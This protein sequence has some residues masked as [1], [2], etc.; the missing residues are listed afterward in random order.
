MRRWL[1]QKLVQSRGFTIAELL[2]VIAVI[3]ILAT[4]V[5]VGYGAVVNNTRDTALKA[6][7]EK[8]ADIIKLE[9]LDND[10][11]PVGGAT[12]ALTGDSTV[13]NG[14]NVT[15]DADSYDI[16]VNNLFYCAGSLADNDEFALVAQSVTGK[17]FAYVSNEGMTELD[18]IP[19]PWDY[20]GIC[21]SVGFEAPYT[22]SYGYNPSPEYGWFA[23]AQAEGAIAGGCPE[24]YIVVPGNAAFGTDDFC[25][26][27]YEAKNVG[28]V[29]TSQASDT[30]W[31]SISQT[32]AISTAAAACSGCH[33]ITDPEW[34]TIAA[35]V[36]SVGSN[37]SGGTVGSGELYRGH[38]DNSPSATIEAG[39]DDGDGFVNTGNVSGNQR[40]T[41]TLTNGEVIWDFSGN[42]QEWVNATIAGGAQPGLVGDAS[43]TT[44]QYND[45]SLLWNGLPS[46]AQPANV[47]S[48]AGSW[49]ST[50][51]IGRLI[52]NYND[53]T[54][55][56][57]SRSGGYS[58]NSVA[59]VLHLNLTALP[60][61]SSVDIG[62]R[63]TK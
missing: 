1:D 63:A 48:G 52:S 33:L 7:L 45:V 35:N 24:N 43:A 18:P 49:S 62:F 10:G 5:I 34:I 50:Q 32:S 22:W 61:S 57:Y 11:I 58:Y 40:R 14:V 8:I 30:P 16:T 23:W 31:V 26:M 27:K 55:R 25:A 41:F 6:D 4:I 42:A 51:G 59:G 53:P 44:K 47:Y 13:L 12:S 20:A 19:S 37:W 17:V 29:A 36:I 60:S 28:G 15:P 38:A 56:A 2:I 9:A 3:G 54:A 46:I 21:T 39:S